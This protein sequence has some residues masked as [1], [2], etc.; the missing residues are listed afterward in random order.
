MLERAQ[1]IQQLLRPQKHSLYVFGGYNSPRKFLSSIE[2]LDIP[3]NDR[4]LLIELQRFAPV[5]SVIF[6]PVSSTEIVIMGGSANSTEYSDVIIY[7]TKTQ[8]AQTVISDCGL[9][10]RS[11]N[12]AVQIRK[13][14]LITPVVSN[15]KDFLVKFTRETNQFEYEAIDKDLTSQQFF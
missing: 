15:Q 13:G 10:F 3:A 7:D 6:Q 1:S 12:Q 14:T 11:Q 8:K 5:T 9:A 4:W 2:V